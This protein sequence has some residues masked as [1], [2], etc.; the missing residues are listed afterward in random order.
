[1]KHTKGRFKALHAKDVLTWYPWI[2]SDF[3]K[4]GLMVIGE[5]NYADGD[6]GPTPEAACKAV[7]GNV[8]FTESVV[9]RFC[10]N[11][12]ERN[13]TF[14]G[15]TNVLCDYGKN[16]I[17]SAG[18]F[19]WNR[20]AYMDVIQRSMVGRCKSWPGKKRSRPSEDM[21]APGWNAVL[22]V[23]EIL[24]PGALLFVGAGVARHF[25]TKYLQ[26]G[27]RADI[28]EDD[29]IG[30]L[31]W[32]KGVLILPPGGKIKVCAIPNPGGAHGFSP[33]EWRPKVRQYIGF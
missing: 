20:I 32:R 6:C 10:T 1:M 2:G 11:R 7:D 14:D 26:D 23:I 30:H 21:W 19:V 4:G 27:Y 22:K 3:T 18:R 31:K 28:N 12:R 9:S 17:L 8:H 13:P 25:S 33:K 16:D 15:I 29:K 24:Q 5:S